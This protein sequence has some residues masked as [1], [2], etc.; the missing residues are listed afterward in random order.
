MNTRASRIGP[1]FGVLA[2][3]PLYVDHVLAAQEGG[4]IAAAEAQGRAA[5]E[6]GAYTQ[7]VGALTAGLSWAEDAGDVQAQGRFNFFLGRSMQ[8]SAS[9]LS[10]ASSSRDLLE[11]AARQ[12]LSAAER[13]PESGNALNNLARVYEAL[14]REGR[15]ERL[16]LEAMRRDP[17]NRSV[18]ARNLADFQV[19][20]GHLAAA[21]RA[22]RVIGEDH[23][24]DAAIRRTLVDLYLKSGSPELVPYLWD[25]VRL[26]DV[27][28][29]Q[30]GALAA[31]E[32]P[33][34]FGEWDRELLTV[35]A[36]SLARRSNDPSEFLSSDTAARLEALTGRDVIGSGVRSLLGL[37]RLEPHEADWWL[38][39]AN[40]D[41]DPERGVWPRDAYRELA[42]SVG[43]WYRRR[44]M[45]AEAEEYFLYQASAVPGEVDPGALQQLT[46]VYVDQGDLSRVEDLARR[47]EDQLFAGKA[48]AYRASRL[49]RIYD[50]HRTLGEIY[51]QIGEYGDR[52]T[53]TSAVFQLEHAR[54][55][56]ELIQERSGSAYDEQE[57]LLFG[58]DLADLLAKAYAASGDTA[59]SQKTRLDAAER[60]K[61]AGDVEAAESVLRPIDR[62]RLRGTQ[63][64]RYE[65]IRATDVLPQGAADVEGRQGLAPANA[66]RAV[67]EA[68]RAAE[69]PPAEVA[70]NVTID[71]AAGNA[72]MMQQAAPNAPG[73]AASIVRQA[74][75]GTLALDVSGLD[76]EEADGLADW[77]AAHLEARRL[78]RQP[79]LDKT[80]AG[81]VEW[82]RFDGRRGALGLATVRGPREIAFQV[83][84]RV[85]AP[86]PA[87]ESGTPSG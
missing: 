64:D 32:M 80:A 47:Y 63:L 72:A 4:S 23:P 82:I 46:R 60:Y 15:S 54:E 49:D 73:Q 6:A 61:A 26:K 57:R 78:G 84:A 10:D 8:D 22:Y 85:G 59:E 70:R 67:V 28:Q 9:T 42:G 69:E 30:E 36:V 56:A 40:P 29:A 17:A 43:D 52:G 37:Y 33:D 31:L 55:A 87:F 24:E 76:A 1:V 13:L 18:Y 11:E 79:Q 39:Q 62:D 2:I 3:F 65:T 16:Y 74:P 77:V 14:G 27:Q 5:L 38:S 81:V 12:Y 20:R 50:Y 48:S 19:E 53:V 83:T 75:F 21:A 41:S 45:Y 7:A 58:P 34:A 51:T 71:A 68:A 25:L 44:H 86:V 35:V 66:N